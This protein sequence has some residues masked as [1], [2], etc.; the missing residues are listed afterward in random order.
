DEFVGFLFHQGLL[1]GRGGAWFCRRRWYE[2]LFP[3]TFEEC[4]C[5]SSAEF[6]DVH[7]ELCDVDLS[8]GLHFSQCAE[9]VGADTCIAE[10]VC[11]FW[12]NAFEQVASFSDR[13]D[14]D[15]EGVGDPFL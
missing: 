2:E 7:H 5:E 4:S 14:G 8:D 15:V 9:G 13:G 1:C 11:G 12:A 6:V 10:N 3:G